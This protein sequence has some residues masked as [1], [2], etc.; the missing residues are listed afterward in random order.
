[1]DYAAHTIFNNQKGRKEQV[2]NSKSHTKGVW[3]RATAGYPDI[4]HHGW[5][6]TRIPGES[7][8]ASSKSGRGTIDYT[9]SPDKRCPRKLKSERMRFLIKKTDEEPGITGRDGR[10]CLG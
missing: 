10:R 7:A 2:H 8:K 3:A 9:S 1:M 4:H 5:L 6:G